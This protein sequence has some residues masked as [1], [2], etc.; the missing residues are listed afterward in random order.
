MNINIIA[1]K[2]SELNNSHI[3]SI[4]KNRDKRKKHLIVAPD[5]SLFSIEQRLFSETGEECFFDV[6]VISLTKLSK[7]LLGK[8]SN[9]INRK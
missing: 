6:S 9:K 7:T 8:T 5:R 4:L 2:N 3:F 1:G